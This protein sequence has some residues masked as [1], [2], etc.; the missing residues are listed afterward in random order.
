[1]PEVCRGNEAQRNDLGKLQSE[2]P[3]DFII[4][5]DIPSRK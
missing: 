2:P 5:N 1:M 4:D 3:M